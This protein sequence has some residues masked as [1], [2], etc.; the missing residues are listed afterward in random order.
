MDA[1]WGLLARIEK[2]QPSR[3]AASPADAFL[4]ATV[5]MAFFEPELGAVS[6]PNTITW[7]GSLLVPR[8]G[9]YRMGFSSDDTMRL[10]IDGQPVQVVSVRPDDWQTVG[11]GSEVRLTE[12]QHAV[13]VFLDVT[14]G[15]RDVARWNWVPPMADGRTDVAA[16][17]AVV[18][19]NV[20]RPDPPVAV[21]PR[22]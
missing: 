6:T 15:G 9:V 22:R 17:W 8:T 18:P 10:E 5:A 20:L 11:A 19:P 2:P 12:G 13:R 14:H 21:A 7:S 3:S 16:N 4:D 1:P